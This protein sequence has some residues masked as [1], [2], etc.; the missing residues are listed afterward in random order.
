MKVEWFR[1]AAFLSRANGASSTSC[2]VG[3]SGEIGGY[4]IPAAWGDRGRSHTC[5]VGSAP[6]YAATGATAAHLRICTGAASV[7]RGRSEG[8][9]AGVWVAFGQRSDSTRM[10]LGIGWHSR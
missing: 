6:R 9:S 8:V 5:G 1:M 7:A 3:R 4:H 2:G 10:A